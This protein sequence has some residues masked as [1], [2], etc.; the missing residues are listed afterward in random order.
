M[1]VNNPSFSFLP[2]LFNSLSYYLFWVVRRPNH[3][4]EARDQSKVDMSKLG[5]TS[6]HCLGP[7]DSDI[8]P[9]C[10][11]SKK[12]LLSETHMILFIGT[13]QYGW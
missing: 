3:F 10:C 4:S 2:M 5:I 13:K 8:G 7:E 9:M 11:F 6:H 1:N 12:Y